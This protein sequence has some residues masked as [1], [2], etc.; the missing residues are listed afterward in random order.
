MST[1]SDPIAALTTLKRRVHWLQRIVPI[2]LILLVA[3]YELGPARWILDHAGE[4]YH[5]FVDVLI[6]GILGPILAYLPLHFLERWL[7]ERE[8]SELQARLLAHTR[9]LARISHALSDD[10]LQTLFG[11]SVM[12]ATLKA[13]LT[14]LPPGTAAALQQ[15]EA[16]LERAIQQIRDHLENPPLP[17]VT[18]GKE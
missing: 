5:L 3:L 14:D 6:Y 18:P 4:D 8:T 9:E 7:E 1:Q 10:A 12:L 17:P 2:G 13:S 15:T 11:A 16:A